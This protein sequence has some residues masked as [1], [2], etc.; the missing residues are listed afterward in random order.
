M[1]REAGTVTR[2]DPTRERALVARARVDPAAFGELYDFYL[3][4][5]TASSLADS[6]IDRLPRTSPR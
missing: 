5:S 1:D 6:A 2:L 4:A 3:R